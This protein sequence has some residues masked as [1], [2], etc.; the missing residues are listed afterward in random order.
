LKK[1]LSALLL[2]TAGI[3][4]ATQGSAQSLPAPGQSKSD[5]EWRHA[6]G[7]Y[8]FA[9]LRTKGTSTIGGVSAGIDM[10]L[11][12]VLDVLDFAASGRYEAW[13]GDWGII[14]DA[15]YASISEESPLGG[16]NVKVTS[17]QK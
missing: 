10:N 11:S 6:A 13:K 2:T 7:V 17:R 4:A 12:D 1:S 14:F 5:S 15:N 16:G 8:L 3:F 9:P